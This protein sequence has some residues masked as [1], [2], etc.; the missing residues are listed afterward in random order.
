MAAELSELFGPEG[1]LA[2]ALPGYAVRQGQLAMAGHVSAAMA[3]HDTLV[4]EAGTGT[5][6]TFAYLVPALT[7]G[8]R[9]IIS[10]GTRALQDQLYHRDL[11]AICAAL[12][13][14]VR[15]ALLKGRANYLC[16]HRLD[17]A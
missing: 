15:V 4:V 9:V 5:G 17:L 11:P 10:T 6:K 3:G 2:S 1:P 12:G 14:P 16:R 13:R 7:S 8:R